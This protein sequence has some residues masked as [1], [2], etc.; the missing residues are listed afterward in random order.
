M[1]LVNCAANLQEGGL[2]CVP[3]HHMPSYASL[4]V[5]IIHFRRLQLSITTQVLE[6]AKM[7]LLFPYRFEKMHYS[8][9]SVRE[10]VVGS[11]ICPA[12]SL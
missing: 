7:L 10:S 11:N 1:G 5:D 6:G 8:S 2:C 3:G 4:L 9:S 12:Q